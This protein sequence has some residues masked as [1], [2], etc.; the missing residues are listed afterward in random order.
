M[1]VQISPE[2]LKFLEE[3]KTKFENI[4]SVSYMNK[5]KGYIALRSG[6]REDCLHI[7][8]LGEEYGL[9]TEQLPTQHTKIVEYDEYQLLKKKAEKYDKL[10]NVLN[11][12]NNEGKVNDEVSTYIMLNFN[13]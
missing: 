12:F 13:D 9:F 3:A 5:E 4:E 8:G 11:M 1:T 7:F 10:I 6:F 2:V